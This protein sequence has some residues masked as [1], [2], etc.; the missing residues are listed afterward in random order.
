MT[1]DPHHPDVYSWS[2]S[3]SDCCPAGVAVEGAVSPGYSDEEGDPWVVDIQQHMSA[4][5]VQQLL[6]MNEDW[7]FDISKPT[8][9]PH[10]EMEQSVSPIQPP[11][12]ELR[13]SREDSLPLTMEERRPS[14]FR[15]RLP[16]LAH[17]SEG[18]VVAGTGPERQA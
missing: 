1:R 4:G 9:I 8:P 6:Q 15:N 16:P 17:T 10:S 11:A 18:A 12:E 7:M 3:D 14:L 5:P 2:G 13:A